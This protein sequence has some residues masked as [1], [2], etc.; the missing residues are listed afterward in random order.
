[1]SPRLLPVLLL[2]AAV[3]CSSASAPHGY[4]PADTGTGPSNEGGA[5]GSSG[6]DATAGGDDASF[7]ESGAPEGESPEG[8]AEASVC[9]GLGAPCT[10]SATC[11][12]GVASGCG[13][14]NVVCSDAG[15]CETLFLPSLDAGN[16]CCNACQLAYDQGTSTF[17]GWLACNAACGQNACPVTC[18]GP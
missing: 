16:T 2:S 9:T 1:M 4:G 5:S 15:M 7:P 10:T 13:V 8:S 17:D 18:V 14:D 3:A 12:C 6:A 11:Y